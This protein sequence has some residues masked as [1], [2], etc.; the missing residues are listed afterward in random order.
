MLFTLTSCNFITV[1]TVKKLLIEKDTPDDNSSVLPGVGS[2]LTSLTGGYCLNKSENSIFCWGNSFSGQPQNIVP[3]LKTRKIHLQNKSIRDV[4]ASSQTTCVITTDGL[5]Y[6]WGLESTIGSEARDYTVPNPVNM[7]GVLSGKTAKKISLGDAHGCMIASDDFVYCWGENDK[8]QLGNGS[9]DYNISSPVAV[10]VAGKTI[11]S[12][13]SFDDTNCV[14]ASDDNLYCWGNGSNGL[15]GNNTN[16]KSHVPVLVSGGDLGGRTIK[17]F[18]NYNSLSCAIA[19]NDEVYCWGRAQYAV[20]GANSLFSS[21]V[22]KAIDFSG[23]LSG[24][25]AKSI[26]IGNAFGCILADDNKVYCWGSNARDALGD[27]TT[28]SYTSVPTAVVLGAR[29][30]KKI[31][32]S[33]W[34]SCILADDDQVYCWGDGLYGQLGNNTNNT[35]NVPVAVDTSGVLNG[36]TV[37]DIYTQYDRVCALT[38]DNLPFCWGGGYLGDAETM[39]LYSTV[40]VSPVM[41]GVLAGKTITKLSLGVSYTCAIASDQKI[42]CWGEQNVGQLGNESRSNFNYPVATVSGVSDE[43]IQDGVFMKMFGDRADDLRACIQS[44]NGKLYCGVIGVGLKYIHD[45]G[46]LKI[47]EMAMGRN[48]SH[49]CALVDD[50]SVYCWGDNFSGQVGNG[51]TGPF[52]GVL[53]PAKIDMTGVLS[54]KTIKTIAAGENMTCAIASDDLVYCWGEGSNQL[55]GNGSDSDKS[56]PVAVSTAGVLNGKKIKSLHIQ[57]RTA[58]VIADDDK[59]YCWGNGEDGKL[60]NGADD[61]S[62]IPVEVSTTKKFKSLKNTGENV[63]GITDDDYAYCW[64]YGTS[65]QL[66]NGTNS[67]SNI[68][69]AVDMSGVLN[70]KTIK[71]IDGSG[72]NTCLIASDDLPYCFGYGENGELGNNLQTNS[73]VPVSVVTSGVLSGKKITELRTSENSTCVVDS[74]EDVYCWGTGEYYGEV[75]DGL[76]TITPLPVKIIY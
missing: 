18:A 63:C 12:L 59:V 56:R 65:G 70:G 67:S 64:G 34:H 66:G 37:K 48:E 69:V 27:G 7:T 46:S 68:P 2:L 9:T 28:A 38:S 61:N 43:L 36:K 17:S 51:T 6:C 1:D 19:S 13:Y 62:N 73:N 41:S 32:I 40:P 39:S 53:I 74:E 20:V 76:D 52:S 10:D 33:A 25:K 42:Y 23:V 5:P 30:A 21:A 16:V 57:S 26:A 29:T 44:S 8:G 11:K 55:L 58:C 47:T 49:L 4:Y 72:Y 24:K 31:L 54:G 14:I 3:L 50:G 71:K 15:L 60:G 45:F 22:P 75:G 35:S